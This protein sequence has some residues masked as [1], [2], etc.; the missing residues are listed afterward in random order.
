MGGDWMAVEPRVEDQAMGRPP[1]KPP[2]LSKEEQEFGSAA[3]AAAAEKLTSLGCV[4]Y[5]PHSEQGPTN[6]DTL[7]GKDVLHCGV[8][9]CRNVSARCYTC[10][11]GISMYFAALLSLDLNRTI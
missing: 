8:A 4:V 5:P 7:A 11:H 6:W 2:P 9:F 1:D 10:M 3:A